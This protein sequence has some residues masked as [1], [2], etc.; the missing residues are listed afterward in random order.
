MENPQ[1]YI[2]GVPGG[3]AADQ[4]HPHQYFQ[5]WKFSPV[6]YQLAKAVQGGL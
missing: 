1:D 3:Q 6:A 2:R 5:T 4:C